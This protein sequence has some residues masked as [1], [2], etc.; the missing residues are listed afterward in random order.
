[1]FAEQ[2]D[3]FPNENGLLVPI[4]RRREVITSDSGLSYEEANWAKLS[5]TFRR[6]HNMLRVRKGL[7]P[8]P[9]PKVDLY[10][11]PRK[12][13][14]VPVD[15]ESNRDAVAAKRSFL[16]G[17]GGAIMGGGREGFREYNGQEAAD[18]QHDW[19]E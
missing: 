8:I 13:K 16:M 3:F 18:H 6:N 15:H 9:D 12:H 1:M 4:N 14:L 7:P 11:A 19:T 2:L 5:P 10:V 17:G